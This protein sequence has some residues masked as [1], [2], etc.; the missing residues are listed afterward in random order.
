[1]T[2]VD[3]QRAAIRDDDEL[4]ALA[5][6]NDL[7]DPLAAFYGAL[8]TL[9]LRYLQIADAIRVCDPGLAARRA[10]QAYELWSAAAG[11]RHRVAQR[12]AATGSPGPCLTPSLI[13]SRDRLDRLV[14][15]IQRAFAPLYAL[16]ERMD[17]I[18]IGLAIWLPSSNSSEGSQGDDG[19]TR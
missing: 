3:E 16:Y 11:A 19:E 13:A 17:A 18:R 12:H 15:A 2:Y 9:Q 1:M 8:G 7:H 14:V 6:G 10:E 4:Q 5:M